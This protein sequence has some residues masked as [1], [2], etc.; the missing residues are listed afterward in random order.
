[1]IEPFALAGDSCRQH[2]FNSTWNALEPLVDPELKQW[3]YCTVL[4]LLLDGII[5]FKLLE[6]WLPNPSF[7]SM[8]YPL[9]ITISHEKDTWTV[10]AR[11]YKLCSLEAYDKALSTSTVVH[12]LLT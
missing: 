5:C 6:S 3:K 11:T 2:V 8:L 10:Q 12:V 4:A 9:D 7:A 1:M